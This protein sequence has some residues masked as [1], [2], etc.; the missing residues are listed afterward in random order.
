[1]RWNKGALYERGSYFFC[2]DNAMGGVCG[3]CGQEESF[4]HRLMGDLRERNK[5]ENVVA[6]GSIILKWMYKTWN[7]GA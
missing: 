5:F 4:I 6:D 7:S 1:V 3:T 2:G